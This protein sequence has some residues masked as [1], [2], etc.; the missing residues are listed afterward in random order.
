MFTNDPTNPIDRVRFLIGDTDPEV[1]LVSDQW[2]QYYLDQDYSEK[3]T[4]LEIARRILAQYANTGWREREGLIEIYGRERFQS[5]MD[6][7]KDTVNSGIVGAPMPYAGGQS[8]QDMIDN[9]ANVDNVRPWRQYNYA[10]YFS[11][12]YRNPRPDKP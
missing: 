9:D 7:L 3:A 2:Y 6:W 12:T 5:Y 4:A 11:R 8:L 10:D 1:P